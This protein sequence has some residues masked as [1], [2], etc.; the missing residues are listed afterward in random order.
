MN[1]RTAVRRIASPISHVW[2]AN[3]VTVIPIW[4]VPS[5][6]SARAARKWARLE[7]PRRGGLSPPRK[8]SI[9][10]IAIVATMKVVHTQ[11]AADGSTQA[12]ANVKNA[13]RADNE[14][15]RV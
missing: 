2:D 10:G 3:S 4:D 15:R 14:R 1:R 6:R 13:A 12:A 9:A 11:G 8:G 5:E 7:I